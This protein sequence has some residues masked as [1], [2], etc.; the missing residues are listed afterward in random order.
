[1]RALYSF[2]EFLMLWTYNLLMLV[3]GVVVVAVTIAYV[4]YLLVFLSAYI[5][6][7]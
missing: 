2:L 1:M 6:N 4:F 7:L 3:L 5:F